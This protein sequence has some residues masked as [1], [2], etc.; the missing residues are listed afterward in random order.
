M[1]QSMRKYKW[2][3]SL[4]GGLSLLLIGLVV[5]FLV[6]QSSTTKRTDEAEKSIYSEQQRVEIKSNEVTVTV[7]KGK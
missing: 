4:I 2:Q 6:S 5:W 1:K 3:F 7:D